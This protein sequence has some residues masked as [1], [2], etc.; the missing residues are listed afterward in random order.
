V[1]ALISQNYI[2]DAMRAKDADGV[3]GSVRYR[4]LRLLTDMVSGMTDTF[5]MKLWEE[6]RGMG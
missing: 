2:E 4:E 6:L 3:V 5:T 1:F